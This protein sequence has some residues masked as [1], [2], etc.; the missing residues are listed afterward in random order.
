MA[1]FPASNGSATQK[2]V[3]KLP[4]GIITAMSVKKY[5]VFGNRRGKRDMWGLSAGEARKQPPHM[6]PTTAD[7]RETI[8]ISCYRFSHKYNRSTGSIP[9]AFIDDFIDSLYNL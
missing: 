1:F 5:W 3:S 8:P 2:F 9:G 7:P 4:R 6:A